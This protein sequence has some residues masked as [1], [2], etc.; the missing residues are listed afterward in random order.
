[1]TKLEYSDTVYRYLHSI[2]FEPKEIAQL[3]QE[4]IPTPAA[5]DY[6]M[7]IVKDFIARDEGR[8]FGFCIEFNSSYTRIR[9]IPVGESPKETPTAPEN[10]DQEIQELREFFNSVELPETLQL[11]PH[12]KIITRKTV[13]AHLG[14]VEGTWSKWKEP[15][16]RRLKEVREAVEKF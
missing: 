14:F 3:P 9:K 16:L 10:H 8:H 12:T 15:Y 6:F 7:D 13:D 1:M 2:D 5:M 4:V 11:N